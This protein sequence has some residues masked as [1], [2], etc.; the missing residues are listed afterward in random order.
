[1]PESPTSLRVPAHGGQLKAL[2]A[3]FGIPLAELLDFSASIHPVPPSPQILA[4]LSSYVSNPAHLTAYPDVGYLDLKEAISAYTGVDVS[5]IVVGNGVMSLLQAAL[6]SIEAKRCLV[7]VPAFTEYAR[8]L[9]ASRIDCK[10]FYL[11]PDQDFLV[12]VD[13]VCDA[14]KRTASDVL[15]L[16]NPHSPS[17]V[18]SPLGKMRAL[19]RRAAQLGVTAIVDEAFI[20]YEHHESLTQ[21]AAAA[22]GLIVLRSLTKFF[23]VPGLRVAYA[24]AAGAWKVGMERCVPLWPVDSVAAETARLLLKDIPRIKEAPEGN[25]QEREWLAAQLSGLGLHIYPACANYLL[26][27]VKR[28]KGLELWHELIT[29]HRIVT[30]SCANFEGLDAAFIRLGVRSR[31]ENERLIGACAA[32]IPNL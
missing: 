12:D 22:S 6:Q 20:D 18:L 23:A 13:E 14:L 7:L 11:Q 19:V 24:I 28:G 32:V 17:G 15:L 29:R 21:I 10:Y 26:A 5:S 2:A 8:T 3:Q 27:K 31:A 9:S 30:R 4:A 16:A 25:A 1:V